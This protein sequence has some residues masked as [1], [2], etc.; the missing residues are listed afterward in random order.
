MTDAPGTAWGP[1][2]AHV[3]HELAGW[4]ERAVM[5]DALPPP[6]P[7]PAEAS[8]EGRLAQVEACLTR[9]GRQAQE[10][11]ALLQEAEAALA[12]WRDRMAALRAVRTP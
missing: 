12:A 1:V 11:I 10:T 5:P 6:G 4:L 2:V 9:A 8:V 3:E 7:G